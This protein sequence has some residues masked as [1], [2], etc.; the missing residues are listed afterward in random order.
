M[1]IRKTL[2]CFSLA[3]AAACQAAAQSTVQLHN[4]NSSLVY[5]NSLAYG[6]TRGLTAPNPGQYYYGL[7]LAPAG[8]TDPAAFTFSGVYATNTALAGRYS[9]TGTTFGL[10]PGLTYSIQV[11]GWSADNGESWTAVLSALQS[12]TATG[13]YGESAIAT[14]SPGSPIPVPVVI[15]ATVG[16][17]DLMAVPEP[18]VAALV[19]AAGLLA[20][21]STP[22]RRAEK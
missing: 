10:A 3:L 6:G 7:F 17:F 2:I 15:G 5:T 1:K 13:F 19:I 18:S 11:R 9:G 16:S 21:G 12:G 22:A 14:F 20:M 4:D 8:A